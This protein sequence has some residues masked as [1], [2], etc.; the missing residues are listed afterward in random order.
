[1]SAPGELPSL[2]FVKHVGHDGEHHPVRNPAP[3]LVADPERGNLADATGIFCRALRDGRWTTVDIAELDRASLIEF[4][5]SRGPVSNWA[6]DIT[7]ILLGHS[8]EG[9]T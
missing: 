5:T 1:V 4:V 3:D 9:L 7:L 2:D 6:R 8:R